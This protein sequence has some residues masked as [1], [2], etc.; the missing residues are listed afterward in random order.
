MAISKER[1][2]EVKES[3]VELLKQSRAVILTEFNELQVKKMEALRAEIIKVDGRFHVTKNTLLGLAL[4][5]TGKPV[6]GDLLK[7]PTAAGFVLGEVPSVAKAFVDFAKGEDGFSIKGGILQEKVIS[8]SDVEALATLP[9][10][11]QLRA[12]IIGLINGPSQG[13]VSALANGVRQVINVVDAYAKLEE[14]VE[15]AA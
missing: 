11:D 4:E 14:S 12:Q 5:E 8:A 9:S 1:R 2:N 10:L 3:Y 7:G 6:P 13:V 15:A